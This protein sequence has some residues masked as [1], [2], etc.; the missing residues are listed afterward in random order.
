[1]NESSRGPVVR[2]RSR[3]ELQPETDVLRFEAAD[4]NREIT[5]TVA[6]GELYRDIQ[7]A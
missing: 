2:W 1:M 6:D 3:H 5:R 7:D 4:L